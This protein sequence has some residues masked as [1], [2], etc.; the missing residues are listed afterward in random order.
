MSAFKQKL[1]RLGATAGVL[2]A[3]TAA[4]MAVSGATAGSAMAEPPNCV[5]GAGVVLQ[6]EGSTLQNVAQGGWTAFYNEKC[7]TASKINFHYTGTGSGAALKAF[8][9]TTGGGA[10]TTG[11]AYV[12]TDEAPNATEIS[13]V[14][15]H[16]TGVKPVIIPVA[17]TSIAIVANKPASCE[18]EGGITWTDLN[19]LFNGTIK[20]W[21]SLSTIKAAKK[22]ECETAQ[23]SASITRVVRKDGS[24]TTYQFKNSLSEL[25]VGE[26]GA[27]P[28]AVLIEGKCVSEMK[29]EKGET[30][31]NTWKE[32]RPNP[33]L[34]L[35]WPESGCNSGRTA[36]EKV[37][38][39]GGVVKFVKA[40]ANTIGYAAYSDVFANT[41]T[42]NAQPLQ[43]SHSATKGNTFAAPGTG[44]SLAEANCGSR[45]YVVP[46]NGQ[47]GG[48]NTGLE[49]DWSEV[50]GANPTIGTGYPLCTLTFDLSW[51]NYAGI[52]GSYTATTGSAV[53]KYLEY[54]LSLTE[55]QAKLNTE[56]YE[57]LP[58]PSA[59][60][61]NVLGAAQL[62]LGQVE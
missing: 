40:N 2:V 32:L 16:H 28:G 21:A 26:G 20:K 43:N 33:T 39:G 6:G 5:N 8:G 14:A 45:P 3:S 52:G 61:N 42:A 53:H 49:V 50:F 48:S 9:Y 25:E 27:A 44:T 29:N 62:S 58:H 7:P 15:A 24:G 38:G 47:V 36:V 46:T 57:A 51:K 18:L 23:G 54:V 19:G 22:A 41:A 60:A 34:N 56:G 4:L 11:E 35:L 12:G 1:A 17:Q 30:K 37:E 13:E 55:G 59:A 31:P 10:V